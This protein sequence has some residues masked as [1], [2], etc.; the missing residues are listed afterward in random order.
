VGVVAGVLLTTGL[1]VQAAGIERSLFDVPP[2]LRPQV[3]FWKRVFATY[4]ENQVVIHDTDDLRRVYSV[5][6][7]RDLAAREP[8]KGRV[9]QIIAQSSKRERERIRALLV[10]LHQRKGGSDG[11]TDEER[12][13]WNLFADS[14]DPK[15]FLRAAD[16]DRIR[17]QRGLKERFAAAI[18]IAH[19]YWPEMEAIFRQEG[20]PAE[21]TRLPLIESCFNVRAYSKKGAAG[22]WQF[23]PSTGRLFMRIDEVV[24]ERRDPILSSYA[25]ARFL[26]QNYERLGTWP[27]AIT[28][29]N[30]GPNGVAR[31]VQAFGT[32]DIVTI[33]ERYSGPAFKFA[34]RNFY[35]EFLAALEI[36][37][38]HA[39]HL[40][41]LNLHQPIRTDRVPLPHFVHL[42][43]VAD[44]AGVEPETLLELNPSLSRAVYDGKQ[45]I[46][47]GFMLRIPAGS[48]DRFEQRYASLP[49]DKKFDKQKALYVVHR[50]QRGQTLGAIA[51]RYGSTVEE[52]RRYNNLRSKHLIREG[53]VLRI[54][55]G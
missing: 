34:S 25:A 40:G 38:N 18:E 9:D 47:R 55:K 35:P 44:L 43:T 6:D 22:V 45:R 16:R 50:V 52:I 17:S 13:I 54:P 33:I 8:S 4:S 48:R 51:R 23:I 24:D 5:L 36:E 12:R 26:R 2:A 53:Q 1:A 28:A 39:A 15:K 11:L 37:R 19:R 29:Y 10:K 3:E 32:T 21:I 49:H 27:L 41:P 31:A 42:E 46:P 30:H 20:V 14:R 7:F